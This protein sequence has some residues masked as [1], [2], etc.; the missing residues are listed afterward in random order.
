MYNGLQQSLVIFSAGNMVRGSG[1]AAYL[2]LFLIVAGGLLLSLKL[3]P[4]RHRA[5]FLS[6]HRLI[7]FATL[8]MILV[9]GLVFFIDKYQYLT[10][11]DVLVPFRTSHHT[12]EI[13]A[14]IIAVYT[15]GV[16]VV[17]SL[18]T[19]MKKLGWEN[20]RIAHYLAFPCFLISLYHSV[21]LGKSGNVLFISVLY[22]ATASLVI[23][24]TALRVWKAVERRRT[25]NEGTVG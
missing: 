1:Q 25:A 18:R 4:S 7:S 21:A 22:P 20:W 23:A 5:G 14:G 13:A 12:W 19:V 10:W 24:L 3:I 17:T 11:A 6:Y 2:L 16:I 8:I 15:M 9:H